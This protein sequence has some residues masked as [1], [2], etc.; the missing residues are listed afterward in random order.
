MKYIFTSI[1]LL[2]LSGCAS[3]TG[4]NTYPSSWPELDLKP[5]ADGCPRLSGTYSNSG[6]GVFPHELGEARSLT[7][8]FRRMSLAKGGNFSPQT[9]G[10]TWDVPAEANAVSIDQTPETL[11]VTFLGNTGPLSSLIFRRYHNSLSETRFDDLFTCYVSENGIRLRFYPETDRNVSVIPN[12]Y[13]GG[14]AT[15]TFLL[16]AIDGSLIVQ[17][18]SD[19]LGFSAVV[20]GTHLSFDSIWFRYPSVEISH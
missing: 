12:L 15:L 10:H 14:G 13:L 7:D 11:R 1:L 8:I 17:L 9:T 18:R 5:T 16:R 20:V 19:S 2:L 3:L 6:N 4:K